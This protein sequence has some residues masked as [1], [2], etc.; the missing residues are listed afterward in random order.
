VRRVQDFA[1]WD[2][3]LNAG[4]IL[5]P[6]VLA[7]DVA[8]MTR[9]KWK[10]LSHALAHPI[11]LEIIGEASASILANA[12]E[13]REVLTNLIFNAVDAMPHGGKISLRTF[14]TEMEVHLKVSD[15]GVGMSPEVQERIFEPFYTTKKEKG[16]GLGLSVSSN[17]MAA[18]SPSTR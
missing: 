16:N 13:M 11:E 7:R 6:N 2:K 18:K 9:P 17:G 5:D 3:G 8:E 1:R 4:E 10:D 15:T 14:Q 12:S